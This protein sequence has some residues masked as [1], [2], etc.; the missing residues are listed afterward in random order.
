MDGL[1]KQFLLGVGVSADSK[2][3]FTTSAGKQCSECGVSGEVG[4]LVDWW[5]GSMAFDWSDSVIGW[6]IE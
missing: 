1:S 4:G 6:L 3:W 5:T 2:H